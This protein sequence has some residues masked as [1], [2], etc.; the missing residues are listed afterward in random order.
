[1]A[2]EDLY[3][4]YLL[5]DSTYPLKPARKKERDIPRKPW[6]Y[7]EVVEAI[8]ARNAGFFKSLNDSSEE[9]KNEYIRQQN[10]MNKLRRSKKKEILNWKI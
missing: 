1:M 7:Y 3:P 2:L 10:L 6:I 5:F 4:Y 9:S 8:K